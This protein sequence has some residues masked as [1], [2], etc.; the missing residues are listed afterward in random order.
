[1]IREGDMTLEK[2]ARCMPSLSLEE[3]KELQEKVMKSA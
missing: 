2:I 1:M 3:L